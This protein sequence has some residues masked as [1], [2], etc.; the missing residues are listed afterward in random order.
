MFKFAVF[1]IKVEPTT[2]SRAYY[3][4]VIVVRTA[5]NTWRAEWNNY[6]PIE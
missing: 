6:T 1:Q 3:P 2:A 5:I 4:P